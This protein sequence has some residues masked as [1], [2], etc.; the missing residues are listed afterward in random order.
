MLLSPKYV[1]TSE[2]DFPTVNTP[3]SSFHANQKV[4]YYSSTHK[5]WYET[6]IIRVNSNNTLDLKCRKNADTRNVRLLQSITSEVPSEH[7]KH[8]ASYSVPRF[9][10]GQK[11]EYYSQTMNGWVLSYVKAVNPDGSYKLNT[12]KAAHPSLVRPLLSANPAYTIAP[13]TAPKRSVIGGPFVVLLRSCV[14]PN[15]PLDLSACKSE[16]LSNLCLDPLSHNVKRMSGFSGGQNEGIWFVTNQSDTK[17]YCFKVVKSGRK[18]PSVA[19]ERENYTD[20]LSRYPSIREDMYLTF[21]HKIFSLSSVYEVFVMPVAKGDRM[22]ETVSRI[23]SSGDMDQ[24]RDVFRSVGRELRLFHGKYGGTQHGDLQSSNI[25]ID[26]SSGVGVTLID[27]GGMG[28]ASKGDME[29]FLESI[30]LLAKTYGSEFER[31]ATASFI[32]GYVN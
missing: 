14:F 29:Y 27:L 19:S 31:T 26:L 13:A 32:D 5:K 16:L 24:L 6:V 17:L 28:Q 8:V 1:R 11:V 4:E 9:D 7:V 15:R 25:F 30:S 12:K 23:M 10:I 20:I 18:F 3:I 21:P 2:N 22:A